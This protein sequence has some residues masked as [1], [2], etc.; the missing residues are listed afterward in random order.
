[1]NE[2]KVFVG[3]D[4]AK[5]RLDVA[6]RPSAE[7][8]ALSNDEASVKELAKRLRALEPER[9]VL[10]A[11]GGFEVAVAAVLA[12]G[13]LPVVVVNPRQVRDF[14][15]AT[16]TLAKS[17]P[18]DARILAWFGEAL[19]PEVRP[20]ND[21]HTQA[22]A[23]LLKRRRQL[24]E[25]LTAEKNR[26]GLA[27]RAIRRDIKTHIRWL[28]RRLKATD[29][30]LDGAVKASPV[31]RVRDD[32]LKSVPGVG[33]VL[34]VSLMAGLPELGRLSGRKIAALVG[35]AP[36]DRDS[37]TLRGRRC[38]WG[39]RAH[40]RSVLFMATLAATRCNPVMGEYYRRL[41]GA[42]K[43]HKVAMTACMRKL[44]VML[45]A[46]VRDQTPWRPT[47]ARPGA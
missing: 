44:L 15:R 3:I 38:V 12:A 43:P 7:A 27:P 41:T 32:L 13:G 26:L 46:M 11:S 8:F 37:G 17:D 25:M 28:Q 29:H 14:A 16:G 33:R 39:G 23:A 42:G 35:V 4:V 34:S 40:L 22:L 31:W 1:M 36:M 5:A 6:V 10:E 30:D 9:V 18:I 21:E 19:R 45:N 24:V 2:S 20:L 47:T